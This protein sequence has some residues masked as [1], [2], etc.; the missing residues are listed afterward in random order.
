[1]SPVQRNAGLGEVDDRESLFPG[2]EGGDRIRPHRAG[3]RHSGREWRRGSTTGHRQGPL[4]SPCET[5]SPLLRDVERRRA[6]STH[7]PAL[8]GRRCRRKSPAAILAL[9]LG[10]RRRAS[11]CEDKRRAPQRQAVHRSASHRLHRDEHVA[12]LQV[13]MD[14]PA[15][16]RAATHCRSSQEPEDRLMVRLPGRAV[17]RTCPGSCRLEAPSHDGR[18]ASSSRSSSR[19]TCGCR[20]RGKVALCGIPGRA[21]I[22]LYRDLPAH[23]AVESA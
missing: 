13:A 3:R 21:T 6:T 12:G 15:R 23:G 19:T 10:R 9:R 22:H 16:W 18:S 2:R 20:T 5:P 1:M 11:W 14:K 4:A 7:R 17:A 8:R